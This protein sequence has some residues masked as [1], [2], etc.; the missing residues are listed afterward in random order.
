PKLTEKSKDY[1]VK[2]KVID[3]TRPGNTIRGTLFGNDIES[4]KQALQIN[5]EYKI[6]GFPFQQVLVEHQKKPNE[7]QIMFDERAKITPYR[8]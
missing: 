8:C 4:F 5:G 1:K 6:S 3:K 2:V 7:Y